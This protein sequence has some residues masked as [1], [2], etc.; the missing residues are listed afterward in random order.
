MTIKQTLATALLAVALL[1]YTTSVVYGASLSTR[2]TPPGFTVVSK[3]LQTVPDSPT[4]VTTTDTEIYQITLGNTTGGACT[5]T[6][7]DRATSAKTIMSSVSVAANYTYVIVWPE[8]M[9]MDEGFTWSSGT[10][11]C[12]TA[13]VKALKK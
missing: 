1:P 9:F 12:L 11:S 10:A 4:A 6:L 7:A 13:G 2:F 5:F 3:A 8:G